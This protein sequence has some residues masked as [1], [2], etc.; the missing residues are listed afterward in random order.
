[1]IIWGSW[2]LWWIIEP[3]QTVLSVLLILGALLGWGWILFPR[4]KWDVAWLVGL[5]VVGTLLLP[6]AWFFGPQS[7]ILLLPIGW[8]H[9]WRRRWEWTWVSLGRN[10]QGHCIMLLL[11]GMWMLWNAH[12]PIVDTDALYYHNALPKHM[13]LFN[14]LKGGLLAPNGSRPLIWHLP[15]TLVYGLGG[16]AAVVLFASWTALG[17]WTSLIQTIEERQPGQ[18]WWIWGVLLGSFSLLEQS[19]LTA[20]N[21][22]VMWWVWIAYREQRVQWL[23]GCLLGFAVAGKFTAAG[24]A[25]LIGVFGRRTVLD[26]VKEATVAGALVGIWSVRNLFD[27]LH[28][29]FP[30]RGWS[31]D[32]PFVWVEKYGMGRGFVDFFWAPWNILMHAKIDQ[33]Q[34]LGQLSPVFV[35]F[36]LGICLFVLRTKRWTDGLL[37]IG[38]FYFWFLGPHWIRHLFPMM[39]IFLVLGASYRVSRGIHFLFVGLVL[40]GVPNNLKPF[41]LSQINRWESR[42]EPTGL[43]ATQW[44]NTHADEGKIALFALWTGALLDK[45][46]VLSSVE[47]HTPIRHLS[48]L[49]GDKTIE[50]LKKEGVRFVAFGPHTFFPSAYPF[51]STEELERNWTAPMRNLEVQLKKEG[52]WVTRLDGVDIYLLE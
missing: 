47:D 8:W 28:P 39:G 3:C 37:L 40:L 13:W 4:V 5:G 32:M 1:M 27:G 42:V 51:L 35:I 18:G 44:L 30:Y 41:V 29:L 49:Y 10:T 34:F 52:R 14:E 19:M 50:H 46:Y 22:V 16:H 2:D 38:S 36:A 43:K 21:V 25:L 20:N 23:W 11:V 9:L 12:L 6:F 15:L 17:A 48:L 26:K 45:P 24:V 33:F 7:G 31:I